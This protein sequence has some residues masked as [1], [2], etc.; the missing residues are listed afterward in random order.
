[1]AFI[2]KQNKA[3]NPADVGLFST[4]TEMLEAENL[5]HLVEQPGL[6]LHATSQ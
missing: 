3:F 6:R 5:P 2:M 1:M 4:E